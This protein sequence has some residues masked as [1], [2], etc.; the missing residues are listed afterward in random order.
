M[1]NLITKAQKSYLKNLMKDYR[2]DGLHKIY[3][4]NVSLA[5]SSSGGEVNPITNEPTDPFGKPAGDEGFDEAIT[6]SYV[7]GTVSF[8]DTSQAFK[9]FYRTGTFEEGIIGIVTDYDDSFNISGVNKFSNADYLTI[10]SDTSKYEVRLSVPGHHKLS[11]KT[12]AKKST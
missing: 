3:I 1:A 10:D 12:V 7:Y 4:V 9:Q 8:F 11:V 2:K 5:I 6:S